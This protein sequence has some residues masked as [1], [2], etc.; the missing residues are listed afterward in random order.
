[1][2]INA[3][4][5]VFSEKK[6]PISCTSTMKSRNQWKRIHSVHLLLALQVNVF[7]LCWNIKSR[8]VHWGGIVEDFQSK[9]KPNSNDMNACCL[10]CSSMECWPQ[11]PAERE[12]SVCPHSWQTPRFVLIPPHCTAVAW[13]RRKGEMRT[14][15]KWRENWNTISAWHEGK[16]VH[17]FP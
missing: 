1:M 14:P 12:F 16:M 2:H 7:C 9:R 11:T 5:T 8:K 6:L 10:E 15:S 17:C 13:G 3:Y 4:K